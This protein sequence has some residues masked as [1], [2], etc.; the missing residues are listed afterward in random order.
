[1]SSAPS[2]PMLSSVK[3]SFQNI[4]ERWSDGVEGV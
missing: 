2:L 1:V 3:E 4:E